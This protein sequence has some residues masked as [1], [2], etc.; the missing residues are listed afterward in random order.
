V[1]EAQMSPILAPVERT[2]IE[3]EVIVGEE[4]EARVE[5]EPSPATQADPSSVTDVAPIGR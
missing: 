5:N 2:A 1:F 4:T 3:P